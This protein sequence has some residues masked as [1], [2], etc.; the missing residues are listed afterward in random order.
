MHDIS[1]IDKNFAVDREIDKTGLT[2]RSAEETPFEIYGV[3]REGDRFRRMPEAVAETVSKGVLRLHDNAAGGRV[4]FATDS[5]R[6]AIRANLH[7]I[8]KMPHFAL[9]GSAGLDLYADGRYVKTFIPPFTVEGGY[10]SVIELETA[11]RREITINFPLYTGVNYLEIGLTEDAELWAPAP[12]RP[13][14]PIVYYGSSITQG[15][16]A[17]RPGRS[18]QSVIE[19]RL[20]VDY[21]NL[22]FCGNA[23]GE[24]EMGEYI[25]NL[26]MSVFVYDYDHNAKTT[27]Q[28]QSTH[29]PMFLQ[30]REANPDLPIVMMNRPNFYLSPAEQEGRAVIETTYQN[31]LN[32]GDRNVYFIS[33]EELCA[34]CLDEGTV[35]N[36]HPTDYGFASMAKAIGDVLE[37]ILNGLS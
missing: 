5:A 10:E 4:R 24:P 6:I 28:L 34:L 16:C 37:E 1:K 7:K 20:N 17:S 14:K 23:K 2:F 29:E 21:V 11:E 18:Y 9:T 19:R 30:I 33:N 27:E 31:A 15:G 12:Y 36:C 22:G 3:F 8:G 32:R 35:D 26:P 25:K 13:L